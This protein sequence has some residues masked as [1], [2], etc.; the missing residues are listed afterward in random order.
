[1]KAPLH[2]IVHAAGYDLSTPMGDTEIWA[3]DRALDVMVIGPFELTQHLLPSLES[4]QGACL[5]FIASV[6]AL[7]TEPGVSAYAAAKGAQISMVRSI[8]QDLG[9][10]KIRAVSVSPGYVDTPLLAKWFESQPDP[11][12]T[13][14]HADGLHPLG[15]IGQAED[16]AA[17]VT[18]LLSP[19]AEFINGANLVIDGGLTAQLPR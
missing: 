3:F 7:A 19:Q 2:G 6:H 15:R 5:V 8:A 1:L 17:L 4:A 11:A 16:I 14:R 9:P 12:E 10:K 13:R 18:F